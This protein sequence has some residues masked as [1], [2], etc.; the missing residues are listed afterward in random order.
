MYYLCH[1]RETKNYAKKCVWEMK[2]EFLS[3]TNAIFKRA[4]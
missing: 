2:I 1:L 3:I 4:L